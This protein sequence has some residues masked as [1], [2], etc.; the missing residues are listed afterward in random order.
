MFSA[1]VPFDPSR[2]CMTTCM[3][4]AACNE[5]IARTMADIAQ[6]QEIGKATVESIIEH[7][8][9]VYC[10]KGVTFASR[11]CARQ[12]E[13]CCYLSL[14]ARKQQCCPKASVFA[15]AAINMLQDAEVREAFEI[16]RLWWI[17]LACCAGKN[18]LKKWN[19]KLNVHPMIYSVIVLVIFY[20]G[21]IEPWNASLSMA[22]SNRQLVPG[23]NADW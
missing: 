1:L 2:L 8:A 19:L 7:V 10:E 14:W 22:S 18:N 20:T 21:M 17:E 12:A 13:S 3:S 5:D 4:Y 6:K 15:E 11:W 23:I 9:L 16:F